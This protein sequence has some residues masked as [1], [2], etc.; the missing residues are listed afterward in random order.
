MGDLHAVF[1]AI[2]TGCWWPLSKLSCITYSNIDESF[3]HPMI[4]YMTH[5]AVNLMV[6]NIP[7][8]P[9]PS[10]SNYSEIRAF[11]SIHVINNED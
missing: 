8:A 10:C 2:L 9:E 6:C 11:M 7:L 1:F 3:A 5:D 4:V